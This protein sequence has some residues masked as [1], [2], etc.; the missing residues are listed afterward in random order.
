MLVDELS[1]TT[2]AD[3]VG[4]TESIGERWV[5]VSVSLPPQCTSYIFP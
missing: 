3:L 2:V 1:G 5:P 4:R